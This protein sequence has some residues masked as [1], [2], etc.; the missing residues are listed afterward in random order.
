MPQIW[1]G[2][3][4]WEDFLE[5][6]AATHSRILAWKILRTEEPDGYSPLSHKQLDTTEHTHTRNKVYI[7]FENLEYNCLIRE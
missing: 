7:Y 6:E 5:E 1:V 4:A 3:L 2:S